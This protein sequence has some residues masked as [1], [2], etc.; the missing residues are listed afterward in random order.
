M[1]ISPVRTA[2]AG[3]LVALAA[4]TAPAQ[5]FTNGGFDT[6]AV[7]AG[8]FNQITVASQGLTGWTVGGADVLQ[9]SST[10]REPAAPAPAAVTFNSQS[11]LAAVDI[12]G[13]GNT[14]A[15]TLSQTLTLTAGQ[16]YRLSFFV[17]RADDGGASGLY[18]TASSVAAAVTGAATASGT[19][20]NSNVTTNAVNF[21]QF[22]LDFTAAASGSA[23]F[24]FTNATSTVANGGNNYAGLD[25]VSLTPVPEPAAV[26]LAA[27]AGLGLV[28]FVRRRL[29]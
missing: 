6:P 17:G 28:G 29:V 22:D 19:F 2:F 27:T 12:T 1:R 20:T 8:A 4:S 18:N 11:G 16:Q 23:V 24:T 3:L 21:Q 13:A 26:G 5:Q 10:Y 25:S 9:I 15:N 14:G 7:T